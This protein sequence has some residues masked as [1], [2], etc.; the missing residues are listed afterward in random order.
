MLYVCFL[1]KKDYLNI[2]VGKIIV[3][4]LIYFKNFLNCF[5]YVYFFLKFKLGRNM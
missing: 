4:F 3:Y 1:N 2:I 5:D